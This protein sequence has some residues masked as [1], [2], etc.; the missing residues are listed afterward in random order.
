MNLRFCLLCFRHHLVIHVL[1]IRFLCKLNYP[2]LELL[3]NMM[4]LYI[5]SLLN[6]KVFISFTRTPFSME[7]T[8]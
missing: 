7:V 1:C 6:F 8:S 2:P 3:F 5:E 4:D